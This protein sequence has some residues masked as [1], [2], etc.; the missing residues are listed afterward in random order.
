MRYTSFV[1]ALGLLLSL[2]ARTQT[3]WQILQR[4]N[5][6]GEESGWDYLSVEPRSPRVFLSRGNRVEVLDTT[7]GRIVGTIPNTL[8]V[9]GITFAEALNRGYTSNGRANS[10]TA[11]ALDTLS[12]IQEAPIPGRNP[13]AIVFEPIGSHIFTFNGSSQDVTVLDARSLAVITTISAP[14][15]PEFA[16]EDGAGAVFVNIESTPGQIMAIDARTLAAKA[17]WPLSGC[18][19]PTGLAIDAQRHRLFSVCQ[20]KVMVVIDSLS[21]KQVA[22]ISIG[23]HPDATAYDARLHLVFSSNGDGT[24][25]IARQKSADL[26]LPF[27]TVST[28][29]GART[30]ALDSATGRIYLVT[31]DFAPAVV[32][33]A[34][35][36]RPAAIPNSF[37]VLQ[38][39]TP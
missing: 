19:N 31:A 6:G 8:G 21:G 20:N 29:R 14:G 17:V 13:D 22:R 28:Q 4:W 35:R 3:S 10:V 1:V 27:D 2:P 5:L 33:A 32:G 12:L 30:M 34:P 36:S 15:K 39:G 16:V 18:D 7:S 25:S 9:H 38:V 26:Y 24:L 11:F 37:V 23:G